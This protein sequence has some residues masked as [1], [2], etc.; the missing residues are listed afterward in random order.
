M[1]SAGTNTLLWGPD[2]KVGFAALSPDL[3]GVAATNVRSGI[4]WLKIVGDRCK[5]M[6]S[7]LEVA[8]NHDANIPVPV[9]FIEKGKA[10]LMG[11]TKGQAVILNAK[12]GRRVAVLD[13]GSDKTWAYVFPTGGSQ[14]LATGDRKCE[15]NTRI[16]VWIEDSDDLDENPMY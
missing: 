15:L 5:K 9:L 2:E 7:S 8:P 1:V 4:D 10:V 12:S 11:S 14:M 13:H 6:S 3:T 16:K